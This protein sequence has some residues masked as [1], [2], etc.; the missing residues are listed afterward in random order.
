MWQ[1]NDYIDTSKVEPDFHSLLVSHVPIYCL[2]P[3]AGGHNVDFLPLLWWSLYSA[4]LGPSRQDDTPFALCCLQGLT[5]DNDDQESD[6]F[7]QSL[8]DFAGLLMSDA[9]RNMKVR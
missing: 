7:G 3:P 5:D 1:T 6:Y 9:L 4:V 8:V 2:R